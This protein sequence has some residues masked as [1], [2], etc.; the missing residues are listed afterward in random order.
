MVETILVEVQIF[1]Q[2]V[3][4]L[5]AFFVP[6]VFTVQVPLIYANVIRGKTPWELFMHW[7]TILLLV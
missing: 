6:E 7:T 1:G 3:S 4:L 5:M 2:T